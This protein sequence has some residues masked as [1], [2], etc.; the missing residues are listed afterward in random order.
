MILIPDLNRKIAL[1]ML[2]FLSVFFIFIRANQI[3]LPAI[4]FFSF[5]V[6]VIFPRTDRIFDRFVIFA[7]AL[8]FSSLLGAIILDFQ[9]ARFGFSYLLYV[10]PLFTGITF[11]Y[12]NITIQT[13]ERWIT[14][15]CILNFVIFSIQIISYGSFLA[16]DHVFGLIG[17]QDTSH[18]TGI[19]MSL[20]SVF[21]VYLFQHTKKIK[22]LFFFL[23][24]LIFTAMTGVTHGIFAIMI[25]ISIVVI[26][27]SGFR[28][29]LFLAITFIISVIYLNVIS[30]ILGGNFFTG[31]SNMDR[32]VKG[33]WNYLY[34]NRVLKIKAF[35]IGINHIS[36]RPYHLFF[37][38]GFGN[39]NDRISAIA[40]IENYSP[41]MRQ[42]L[43]LRPSQLSLTLLGK[44]WYSKSVSNKFFSDLL[45][46][47]V[48][49]GL[50]GLFIFI[51]AIY[52][53]YKSY[54]FSIEK[55]YALFLII[56]IILLGVIENWL[57]YPQ[58]SA[59]FAL[60]LCILLKIDKEKIQLLKKSKMIH[61]S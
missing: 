28:S 36:T 3:V 49:T 47:I 43:K 40:L 42:L 46:I 55:L 53:V 56:Y 19:V 1:K 38:V 9:L 23:L 4:A 10:F 12:S 20:T 45:S 51:F 18:T 29:K 22:H 31:I 27:M 11:Y 60:I 61:L 24:T 5:V 35:E 33:D 16:G 39:Y 14:V 57:Q 21:W 32:F 59:L 41:K 54:H 48:E 58:V 34:R 6:I 7:A 8:F 15:Y 25:A 52:K 26:F 50:I 13:I 30:T 17:K 37:G 44:N 2:C